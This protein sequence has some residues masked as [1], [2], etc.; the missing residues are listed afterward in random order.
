MLLQRF[1]LTHDHFGMCVVPS[2]WKVVACILFFI[3]VVAGAACLYPETLNKRSVVIEKTGRGVGTGVLLDGQRVLTAYHVV[4]DIEKIWL[5]LPGKEPKLP[6][7][8]RIVKYDVVSDLALLHIDDPVAQLTPLGI[9]FAHELNK[10]EQVYLAGYAHGKLSRFGM[11]EGRYKGVAKIESDSG[12][13][14]RVSYIE[15]NRRAYGGDSGGGIFTCRGLLAGIE[16]GN[17]AKENKPNHIVAVTPD[18]LNWFLQVE[19]R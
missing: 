17:L 16:L 13:S 8:A 12:K 7:P 15:L 9:A 4:D 2:L 3:P 14:V 1:A 6:V 11:L 5:R 10:N 19:G 18:Y